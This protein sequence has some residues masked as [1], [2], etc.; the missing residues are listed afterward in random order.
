MLAPWKVPRALTAAFLV[1]LVQTPSLFLWRS[2]GDKS[3]RH[4]NLPHIF[5]KLKPATLQWETP[6]L[7]VALKRSSFA[8]S[9][10]SDLMYMS[11]HEWHDSCTSSSHRPFPHCAG[12]LPAV[13]FQ[14]P[15]PFSQPFSLLYPVSSYQTVERRPF[16]GFD[17][18]S[19]Q[20]LPTH[21]P[22]E[23]LGRKRN[24]EVSKQGAQIKPIHWV[25]HSDK[26]EICFLLCS[27]PSSTSNSVT[28]EMLNFWNVRDEN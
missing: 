22:Q 6:S 16:H 27:A 11:I 25:T 17:P 12:S 20:L 5:Q 9:W 7:W 13:L 3:T 10:K 8:L 23:A 14:W 19:D 28:D 21:Q 15:S 1:Q 2:L 18:R 4:Q 24:S 26:E